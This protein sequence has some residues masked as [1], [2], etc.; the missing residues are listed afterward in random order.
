MLYKGVR[1][2]SAEPGVETGDDVE[3]A[4][5]DQTQGDFDRLIDTVALGRLDEADR[6]LARSLRRRGQMPPVPWPLR[7]CI[8]EPLHSALGQMEG[9]T[10]QARAPGVFS[11]AAAFSAQAIGRA[12]NAALVERRQ[13][14]ARFGNSRKCGGKKPAAAVAPVASGA[15][16]SRKR[17]IAH[18]ARRAAVSAL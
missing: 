10:A 6:A 18:R 1:D 9:G 8:F 15:G 2:A 16:S 5:G 17:A 7:A 12:T 14:R 3:A 4:F 11:P 13:M